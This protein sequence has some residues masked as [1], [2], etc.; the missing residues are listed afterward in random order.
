MAIKKDQHVVP[1]GGKWSV[2]STGSDRASRVFETK[3]SA[4]TH[5]RQIARN[6]HTGVYV[7]GKDGL[8]QSKHSFALPPGSSNSEKT[9][10]GASEV[11][12]DPNSSKGRK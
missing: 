5:A 8:V 10:A 3:E 4:V 2:R 1:T 6:A 7:H 11:I 9:K 12:K